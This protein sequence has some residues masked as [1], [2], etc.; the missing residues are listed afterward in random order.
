M[1]WISTATPPP[2]G[3]MVLFWCRHFGMVRKGYMEDGHLWTG[4]VVW[5]PSAI[6]SAGWAHVATHWMETPK[7]PTESPVAEI[8]RFEKPQD[9]SQ[10]KGPAEA[11]P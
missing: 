3:Q 5:K 6:P 7:S 8:V 4:D 1:R 11:S 10:N 9:T 2:D